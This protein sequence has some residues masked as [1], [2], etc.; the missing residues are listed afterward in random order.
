[1]RVVFFGD[2]VTE[3]CFELFDREN[4]FD[5]VRDFESVYHTKLKKMWDKDYPLEVINSG[6]SGDRTDFALNRIE[7]D[8]LSHKPDICVVAFGLNDSCFGIENLPNY[9]SNLDKIFQTLIDNSIRPIFMS[10]NM[11][12]TYVH[13]DTLESAK[14]A[15]KTC[16]KMQVEGVLDQ[17]FESAKRLCKDKGITVVDAYS[18]WKRMYES[19]IDITV[20]LSNYINHPSREMQNLFAKMLYEVL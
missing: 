16:V 18:Q 9:T 6:I 10:E 15:A 7:R 20:H 12:A 19:G 4:S 8:V 14:H 17:Y 1:M 2:S 5:T 11:M 3:G 13:E